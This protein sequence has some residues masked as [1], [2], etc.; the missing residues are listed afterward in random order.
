MQLS[1]QLYSI[2]GVCFYVCKGKVTRTSETIDQ[3]G[4]DVFVRVRFYI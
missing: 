1:K 2:T 3:C 4:T